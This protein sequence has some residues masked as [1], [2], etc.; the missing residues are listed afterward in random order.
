MHILLK[1]KVF[2]R[3]FEIKNS[4]IEN[5]PS[6]RG[7]DAWKAYL[8]AK[9]YYVNSTTA[10]RI[11][12][13]IRCVDVVAKT[14]ASL[15][16]NLYENNANGKEKA[17]SHSLNKLISKLPNP[18][19][20]AYEFWHM[21]VFNLMLTEG[22]YA[23]IVR[24]RN[25]FIKELWNIPTANVSLKRNT[26]NGERYILIYDNDGLIE[27]LREGEFM[28]TPGL[29]FTNID[30]PENP[31]RIASDVLGLTLALN[32]YA[33]DFFENGTNLGGF[34]ESPDALS[35]QAYARFKESWQA[36]YVGVMN[37]HKVAFL[38]DGLK[39]N[40]LGKNPNDSQALESRK[41]EVTEICRLFG[42]PP[43][44][45][46][47]LDRATFSNIEQQNI[48][49]VQESIS[50]MS[51]RIEQTVYKDLLTSVE[52]KR[53]YSKLNINALLRGD[54]E[55][56]GAFYHNM[57]QDGI[58]NADEIRA[59]ED[60]NDIPDGSGKYYLINGNMISLENAKNNLP[61]SMQNKG[62]T[63]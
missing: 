23:K 5:L 12:A 45:V 32:G 15:P 41:F 40:Q 29:R 36:T 6:P 25:G 1:F 28:Y 59:L 14:I 34:I 19:T 2:G 30:T 26:V 58:M 62:G 53:Y 63:Q 7:D 61:K 43:H 3:S 9:G 4:A 38:E 44:K 51:V 18:E 11:A 49:Y 42:V 10:I 56:R 31:I 22:A 35:D 39:F 54:I 27:R 46:F 60:M 21:Y 55:T 57:R 33:K 48:E 8:G 52:Q 37:Q 13:V 50:P 47:D 24:D 20:T 17:E 16:F